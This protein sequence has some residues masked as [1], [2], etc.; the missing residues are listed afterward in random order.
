[1]R[2][3]SILLL[4]GVLVALGWYYKDLLVSPP[5]QPAENTIATPTANEPAAPNEQEI[6][7]AIEV[8]AQAFIESLTETDP[9]PIAVEGADHF[10]RAD[11]SISLLP[12]GTI[13]KST[14]AEVLS[15]PS[16]TANSPITIV[17]EIEQVEVVSPARL[18][19]ESGGDL[20]Q[21]ITVLAGG[22]RVKTTVREALQT[23]A[24]NPDKPISV[25]K[26]VRHYQITTRTELE[27]GLD[28]T[29]QGEQLVGI[30]KKPYRLEAAT[31]ADLLIETQL[32]D[33][34]SIF[35]VHTIMPGDEQGIWGIVQGGLI[36]NFARGIAIR[37]GKEVDTYRAEIPLL[38]D[39]LLADQTS[40]YLG[41]LIYAK[42]I[43]SY[44][45][46]YKNN[47]MGKNPDS[48]YPGQEILIVKFSAQELIEIYKHFVTAGG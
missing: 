39:E 21:S 4:L 13:E 14:A 48:L 1:M 42:S 30:I 45:Y 9:E 26:K 7:Q 19:A 43:N 32:L 40:S 31:I 20:E 37:R 33:E 24:S 28:L 41:R 10:V 12:P 25:I 44:V 8:E 38:A 18:I 46:N 5:S 23:H 34:D 6:E 17:K 11:Q 29:V 15:D 36:S 27:Q 47:R 2:F 3:A 22:E 35:Y 16:L